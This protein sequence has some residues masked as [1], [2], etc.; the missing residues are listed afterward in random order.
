M[1]RYDLVIVGGGVIGAAVARA[2][3]LKHGWSICVIEKEPELALHQSGRNSGVV[4][5]GY[6]PKPGSLKAK[7]IVEGSRRVRE[8]CRAKGVACVEDGILVVGSR[9]QEGIL[10]ELHARGTANGAKVEWVEGARL[11]ELEPNV[12]ADC[13]MRAPE[14]ASFDSRGYVKALAAEAKAEF[15]VGERV[16]RVRETDGVELDTTRRSVRARAMFNAGGLHA[17]RLAHQLGVG[18]EHQI[19]PFRGEYWELTGPSRELVRSHVYPCPDLKFPFLGVHVSRT[20]DGRCIAG[21]S[22][23]LVPGREAYGR[24]DFDGRDVAEML[25][26]PGLRRMAL[27]A[28][29]LALFRREWRKSFFV[30][31]V[32]EEVRRLVPSV[33]AGD[34]TGYRAGIR[35]QVVSRDGR[36]VDDLVVVETLRTVHALNAVSPALTCSMP[37]ADWTLERIERKLTAL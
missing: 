37:F 28:E 36:L 7:F 21:P 3:S 12:E 22:A 18:R 20:H 33:R 14:G 34:V 25:R 19:V 8:F 31:A 13:A 10:R 32:V 6:N 5:A 30:S 1:D 9:A 27:S 26:W 35:A 17:D 29:F 15:A 4:H 2:A 24:L 11:R 16:L 23:A